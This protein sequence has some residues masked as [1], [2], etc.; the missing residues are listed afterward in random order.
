MAILLILIGLFN[1]YKDGFDASY[2]FFIMAFLA[3]LLYL[4]RRYLRKKP[5]NAD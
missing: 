5:N 2:M 4:A 1:L 3:A